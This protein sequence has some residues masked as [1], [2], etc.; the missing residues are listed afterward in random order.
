MDLT[1]FFHSYLG[2]YL[3]QAFMHS[4]VAA[5]VVDSSISAWNIDNPRVRQ[6]LRL[7]VIIAPLLLYPIYQA[8]SPERGSPWFRLEALF[9]TGRW[10]HISLVDGFTLGA[11]FLVLLL[12]TAGVFVFQELVPI[13]RHSFA[14]KDAGGEW[15]TPDRDSPV[16][17]AIEGLPGPKPA[18]FLLDDDELMLFSVTGRDPAVVM[19]TGLAAALSADEIRAAVAHEMGHID[20]GRRPLLT[21]VFVLRVLSFYNPV[22]LMEFRRIIEEEEKICDDIAVDRTGNALALAGVLRRFQVGENPADPTEGKSPQ[23]IR[24]RI[25][26]YSHSLL[27]EHRLERLERKTEPERNEGRGVLLSILLAAVIVSINYFIV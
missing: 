2:M 3:A 26:D 15:S 11:V 23:A 5:L 16:A 1:S 14:A 6:R 20:R 25:E 19:T 18:L 4:L 10:I 8:V 7:I 13:M 27:M 9:D 17:L 21:A 12:F 24:D 22:A